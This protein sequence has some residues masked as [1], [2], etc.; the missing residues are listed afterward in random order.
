MSDLADALARARAGHRDAMADLYRA[1]AGP[2]LSYLTT[3]VRRHEDAEDLLGEVFLSAMR[4]LSTFSGDIA[5]F[6]AW[7][8]R[9]AS[10]RA[11]DLA[12]RNA[13]RPEDPLAP[14]FEQPS[15]DDPASDAVR[16]LEKERLWAAVEALPTAQREVLTLRLAGGLSAPEIAEVLGKPVGAV[17]SLQHRALANLTKALGGPYP[18]QRPGRLKEEKEETRD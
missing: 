8:Y 13:R 18:I 15:P 10:N 4:D 14:A 1:F 3:Q 6:R 9:I 11:I 2:L 12:R 5:G 7:L 16:S 17:K